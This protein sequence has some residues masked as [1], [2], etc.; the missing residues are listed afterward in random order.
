MEVRA[1]L[2]KQGYTLKRIG[3]EKQYKRHTTV[4]CVR[5]R[6]WPD[7]QQFIADKIGVQPLEIW[8]SCYK[9]DGTPIGT[10]VRRKG[11]A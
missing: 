8:P 9:K 10:G 3:L 2:A 1:A 7:L 5:T 11:A 4:S 6:R